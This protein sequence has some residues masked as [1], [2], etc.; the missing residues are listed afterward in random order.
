M[1]WSGEPHSGTL[2]QN[3]WELKSRISAHLTHQVQLSLQPSTFCAI[4]VYFTST[5]VI[6][7]MGHFYYC[8]IADYFRFAHIFGFLFPVPFVTPED[9]CFHVRSLYPSLKN[10]P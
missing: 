7:P 9:L 1:W 5:C 8:F 10:V 4:I 6:N 2:N 3:F